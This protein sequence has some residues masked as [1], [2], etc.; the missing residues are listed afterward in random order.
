MDTLAIDLD[1][2]ERSQESPVET[3][4][5]CVY[6]WIDWTRDQYIALKIPR[7]RKTGNRVLETTEE[8]E[9]DKTS[10]KKRPARPKHDKRRG[11]R[12]K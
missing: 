12:G 9:D 10:W 1:Q 2:F 6:E 8:R 5:R 7:N 11:G 4:R 3:M